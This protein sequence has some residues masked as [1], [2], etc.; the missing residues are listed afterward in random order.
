MDWASDNHPAEWAADL[1]AA[2]LLAAAV[3]FAAGVAGLGAG[4]ALSAAAGGS[5]IVF[6]ALRN[7]SA[8]ERCFALPA[9]ELAPIELAGDEPADEESGVELVLDD[10]LGSLEPGARVV[11]LFGRGQAP[12]G[13]AFASSAHPDASQ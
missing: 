8:G 1:A 5:S 3:G 12:E 9:F 6:A 2:A 4:A 10:R 13:Y 7:I 11:R